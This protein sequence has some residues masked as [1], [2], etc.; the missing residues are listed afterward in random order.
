L[1]QRLR[2]AFSARN[3]PLWGVTTD[4]S[5]LSPAPLAEVFGAVPHQRCTFHI[6]AERSKAVVGAVAS[7]RKDLAA[8]QPQLPTGRPSTQAAQA[9]ARTT[10]RLAEQGAALFTHR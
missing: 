1:L 9:A 7:A 4:G 10:K 2:T 8:T 5:A 6:M 3:V